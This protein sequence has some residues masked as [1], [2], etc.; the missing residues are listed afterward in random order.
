M[1][2]NETICFQF[3]NF[4]ITVMPRRARS[5]LKEDFPKKLFKVYCRREMKMNRREDPWAPTI[6]LNLGEWIKVNFFVFIKRKEKSS[7]TNFSWDW[8]LNRRGARPMATLEVDTNASHV[9]SRLKYATKTN[10]NKDVVKSG[11]VEMKFGFRT[12]NAKQRNVF[13]AWKQS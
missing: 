9:N 12:R 1:I 10:Q 13:H 11:I 2:G 4:Q 7:R 3:F 5:S 6:S 8:N